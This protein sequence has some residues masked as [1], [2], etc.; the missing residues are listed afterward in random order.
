MAEDRPRQPACEI[1]SIKRR[2]QKSKFQPSK[3]AGVRQIRLPP[4]SGYFTAIGSF[5]VK[6]VADRQKHVAY[7]NK[8]Q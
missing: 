7:H 8:H 6:T 1:F 2:F 5:S 3:C 4:K